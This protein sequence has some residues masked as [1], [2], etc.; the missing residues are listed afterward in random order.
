MTIPGSVNKIA[1]STAAA[2]SVDQDCNDTIDITHEMESSITSKYI[3]PMQNRWKQKVTENQVSAKIFQRDELTGRRYNRIV[4]TQCICST[5]GCTNESVDPYSP[6]MTRLLNYLFNRSNHKKR[7]I[8]RFARAVREMSEDAKGV[9]AGF[10]AIQH[11]MQMA[12]FVVEKLIYLGAVPQVQTGVAETVLDKVVEFLGTKGIKSN[13][14]RDLERIIEFS[15]EMAIYTTIYDVYIQR[16]EHWNPETVPD[17]LPP[18]VVTEEMA[19]YSFQLMS[20]QYTRPEENVIV[21]SLMQ[22]NPNEVRYMQVDEMSP[23]DPTFVEIGTGQPLPT[24]KVVRK[25]ASSIST[26]LDGFGENNAE[27]ILNGLAKRSIYTPTY[28]CQGSTDGT[29]DLDALHP[30][31]S[32]AKRKVQCIEFIEG[33]LLLRVSTHYLKSCAGSSDDVI[34]QAVQHT[35]HGASRAERWVTPVL[36]ENIMPRCIDRN[37]A[38]K[39]FLQYE[40]ITAPSPVEAM[41]TGVPPRPRWITYDSDLEASYGLTELGY[42]RGSLQYPDAF[43]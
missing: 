37:P 12:V 29:V 33:R 43:A 14:A 19:T 42:G 20:C 6:V 32:S 28:S 10:N 2:D 16:G 26:R 31:A 41:L 7:K 30:V 40:D 27:I 15:R 22:H 4:H 36:D 35:Q 18:I 8:S 17:T 1:Y 5:L 11:W 3:N 25:I 23:R 39:P 21:E 34:M 38:D 24:H 9:R 13:S